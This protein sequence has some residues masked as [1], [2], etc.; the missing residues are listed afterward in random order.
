MP[1]SRT[2]LVALAAVALVAETGCFKSY[3]AVTF[4]PTDDA[5]A[6]RATSAAT[7]ALEPLRASL[8]AVAVRAP[9]RCGPEAAPSGRG[10]GVALRSRAVLESPCTVWLAELEKALAAKYKVVGWKAVAAGGDAAVRDA[11][12]ELVLVVR[13][14]T[15]EPVLVSAADHRNVVLTPATAR[16]EPEPG[17]SPPSPRADRMI[18]AVAAARYPDGALAGVRA[19][20]DLAAVPAGG[21]EPVWTYAARVADPLAGAGEARMLVRGRS[22]TWRPVTPRGWRPAAA[23]AGSSDPVDTRLSELAAAV[24]ADA[25]SRLSTER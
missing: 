8:Q 16:G 4:R 13:E 20:V 11:G 1:R 21:G 22:G 12:A 25:V 24:A 2:P 23:A 7:P 15:A 9:A 10:G 19:V 5:A 14:L 3:V 17:A 6:A 18:R